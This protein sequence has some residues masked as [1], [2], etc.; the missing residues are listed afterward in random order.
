MLVKDLIE[1]K[2][3]E[4]QLN[5][6]LD[7]E[8]HIKNRLKEGHFLEEIQGR[9]RDRYICNNRILN[10]LEHIINVSFVKLQNFLKYFILKR[11]QVPQIFSKNSQIILGH[12]CNP[13][14]RISSFPKI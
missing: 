1:N 7:T 9:R 11:I 10:V 8:I 13:K 3:N 6:I 5:I 12:I 2:S 4:Q 14:L